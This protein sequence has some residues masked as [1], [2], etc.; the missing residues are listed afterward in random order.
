MSGG[1]NGGE[2]RD[3]DAFYQ[4]GAIPVVVLYTLLSLSIKRPHFLSAALPRVALLS[5]AL[6]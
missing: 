4:Y 5:A 3:A 6:G 2:T 1:G